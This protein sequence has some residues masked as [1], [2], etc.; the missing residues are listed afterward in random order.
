[1][2]FLEIGTAMQISR[3]DGYKIHILGHDFGEFVAIVFGPSVAKS[4]RQFANCV[5]IRFGLG[6]KRQKHANEKCKSRENAFHVGILPPS[7]CGVE[8]ECSVGMPYSDM[9]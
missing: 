1:M 8:A 3:G 9:S 4:L 6:A 2:K 7:R 5:F